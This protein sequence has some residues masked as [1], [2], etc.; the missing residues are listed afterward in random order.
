MTFLSILFHVKHAVQV[1]PTKIQRGGLDFSAGVGTR[2]AFAAGKRG[3]RACTP[4][5]QG[6]QVL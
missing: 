4:T 1:P 5:S 2:N 6:V 3:H